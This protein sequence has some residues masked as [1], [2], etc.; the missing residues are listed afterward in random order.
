MAYEILQIRLKKSWRGAI[1]VFLN[2]DHNFGKV[3]HK[4]QQI[5][6]SKKTEKLYP[7]PQKNRNFFLFIRNQYALTQILNLL[8]QSLILELFMKKTLIKEV[9]KLNIKN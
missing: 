7:E 1:L 4:K 2:N 9:W 8:L 6:V 5:L 3:F